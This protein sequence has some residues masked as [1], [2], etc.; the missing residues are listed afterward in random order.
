MVQE[1]A[2]RPGRAA[3]ARGLLRRRVDRRPSVPVAG[4]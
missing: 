3:G 2:I 1:T 4:A